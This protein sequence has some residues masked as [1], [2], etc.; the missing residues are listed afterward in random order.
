M[1]HNDLYLWFC[2][3]NLRGQRMANGVLILWSMQDRSR[4][5]DRGGGCHFRAHSPHSMNMHWRQEKRNSIKIPLE[6]RTILLFIVYLCMCM[7]LLLVIWIA[8]FAIRFHIAMFCGVNKRQQN[9]MTMIVINRESFL[10][11][12]CIL[13]EIC[14]CLWC[15]CMPPMGK[16]ECSMEWE[17]FWLLVNWRTCEC[18]AGTSSMLLYAP[19]PEGQSSWW[20]NLIT[21]IKPITLNQCYHCFIE[22]LSLE[23]NISNAINLNTCATIRP[24]T[25]KSKKQIVLDR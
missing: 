15:V 16:L 11:S 12:E 20:K 17:C 3:C 21:H 2:F 10:S 24:G 22:Q 7:C 5:I 13:D 23:P 1:V 19:C 8:F 4:R 18:I 6:V 25:R 14:I 9:R